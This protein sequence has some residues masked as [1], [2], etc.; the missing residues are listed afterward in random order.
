MAGAGPDASAHAVGIGGRLARH[1]RHPP[2]GAM[3]APGGANGAR[4]EQQHPGRV[5]EGGE[6]EGR[7]TGGGR[8]CFW[9]VAR[10]AEIGDEKGR[11][12]HEGAGADAGHGGVGG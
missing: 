6:G 8:G 4:G 7:L 10:V 3:L 12:C 2:G 9:Y 1:F 11:D 5:F